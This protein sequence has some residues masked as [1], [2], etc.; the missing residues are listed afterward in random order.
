MTKS[1][2]P[3][4]IWAYTGDGMG[5]RMTDSGTWDAGNLDGSPDCHP[6]WPHAQYLRAD[7]A[8]RERDEAAARIEAL[9]AQIRHIQKEVVDTLKAN[10]DDAINRAEAAEAREAR[11]REAVQRLAYLQSGGP[12]T[13]IQSEKWLQDALAVLAEAAPEASHD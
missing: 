2:A 13:G 7:L 9:E 6:E 8:T 11:L 3:E 12:C 4:R 5:G 10:E 1:E